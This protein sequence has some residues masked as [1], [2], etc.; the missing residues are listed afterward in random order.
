MVH[1]NAR[2]DLRQ[3]EFDRRT[4]T[5]EFVKYGFMDCNRRRTIL[6]QD[7]KDEQGNLVTRHLWIAKPRYFMEA[8]LNNG[9]IVEFTGVV[10]RYCKGSFT[11]FTIVNP[12]HVKN[13]SEELDCCVV[14]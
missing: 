1:K 6:L 12:Q 8:R 4:Y 9:D 5:G 2:I 14:Y 3:Y 11:D 13:I 10:R 7:I